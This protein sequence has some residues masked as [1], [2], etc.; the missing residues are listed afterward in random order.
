MPG[1]H[2]DL[3]WLHVKGLLPS[4]L[5]CFTRGLTRTVE[6]PYAGCSQPESVSHY[7]WSCVFAQR[8]WGIINVRWLSTLFPNMLTQEV[9]MNGICVRVPALQKTTY[10]RILCAAKTALWK[11]RCL[12]IFGRFNWDPDLFVAIFLNEILH[13]LRLLGRA[14][15]REKTLWKKMFPKPG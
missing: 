8:S 2:S 6:C 7:M 1:H 4:R 9:V 13:C 14:S 15:V 12:A 10:W 5:Q 3:A 11:C